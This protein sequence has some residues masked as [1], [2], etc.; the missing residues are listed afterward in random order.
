M[1]PTYT[2]HVH[3]LNDRVLGGRA[4]RSPGRAARARRR[5]RERVASLDRLRRARCGD[6]ASRRSLRLLGSTA[7]DA[8]AAAVDVSDGGD[9]A[10][11]PTITLTLRSAHEASEEQEAPSDG[12]TSLNVPH[13][14]AGATDAQDAD[15]GA[16]SLDELP[17][18]GP[19][20]RAVDRAGSDGSD[21]QQAP[22]VR[23]AG[24]S[25]SQTVVSP[26]GRA[27]AG[28]NGE[29]DDP[30]AALFGPVWPLYL[31]APTEL[32]LLPPPNTGRLAAG[33]KKRRWPSALRAR[34]DHAPPSRDGTRLA[35]AR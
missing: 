19:V 6:G 33:G 16:S 1:F 9:S 13:A 15:G 32:M 31:P 3:S 17:P 7:P 5:A 10:L 29:E 4:Q 34:F 20:K 23:A 28:Q 12:G 25:A 24:A 8:T 2:L 11:V 30:N 21:V 26:S 14:L 18:S 22:T 27:A 35:Q